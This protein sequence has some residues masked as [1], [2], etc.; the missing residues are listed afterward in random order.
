MRLLGQY[1]VKL[2]S[3]ILK[4]K[5]K[6]N[7]LLPVLFLSMSSVGVV[8]TFDQVFPESLQLLVCGNYFGRPLFF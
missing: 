6:K 1:V 7:R 4:K 2:K 3:E 8:F 5:H